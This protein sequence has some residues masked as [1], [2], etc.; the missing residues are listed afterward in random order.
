MER[1][2]STVYQQP[3]KPPHCARAT[4]P[5][6]KGNKLGNSDDVAH[7][8]TNPPREMT[9]VAWGLSS[10]GELG[11]ASSSPSFLANSNNK[12]CFEPVAVDLNNVPLAHVAA[13][14]GHS[15][16][17]RVCDWSRQGRPAR[18]GHA[19]VWRTILQGLNR[20]TDQG[21]IGRPW[22]SPHC[23]NRGRGR[24]FRGDI[25]RGRVVRMGLCACSAG[26]ESRRAF[27]RAA[28]TGSKRR[29]WE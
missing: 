24:V 19:E 25:F 14:R 4:N 1:T 22:G 12:V 6:N 7:T 27:K 26:T 9:C 29:R 13:G 21:D 23:P 11:L 15:L 16:R 18:A 20:D 3:W 8:T 28:R 10:N 5:L 17:R 2:E